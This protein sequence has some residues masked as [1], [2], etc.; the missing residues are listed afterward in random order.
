MPAKFSSEFTIKAPP[1][2]VFAVI[3]DVDQWDQFMQGLV[4][5]ELLTEGPF[6]KGTCWRERR[7]L[8]GKE[9]TE[10]F[11]V[12]SYDPPRELGLFVDGSEGTTGK[13]EFHFLYT[14]IPIDENATSLTLDAQIIMPG[15]IAN[16]LTRMMVG[17]FK[18]AC[19]KDTAALKTYVEEETQ[20]H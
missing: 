20:G 16:L 14:L 1:E 11:E 15:F 19:E 18:K 5:I 10:V 7:Q 4:N 9:A 2:A 17:M 3:T 8:Y 12:I 13:G 6:G